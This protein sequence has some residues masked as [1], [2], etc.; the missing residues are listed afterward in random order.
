MWHALARVPSEFATLTSPSI[1]SGTFNS[2]DPTAT[3]TVRSV[4]NSARTITVC[5]WPMC[6]SLILGDAWSHSDRFLWVGLYEPSEQVLSH[7][8]QAFGLHDLAIEDAHRAHQRPKLEVYDDSM[9]MSFA[10]PS[11]PKVASSASNSVRTHVFLWP[12][13]HH[14][15]FGTDRSNPTWACERAVNRCLSYWRKVKALYCIRS[16]TLLSINTFQ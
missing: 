12:R 6:P 2:V 16:S 13:L 3:Q 9:F 15:H 4:I 10:Q 5:V 1:S 8:Q 14:Y 11:Y 7:I